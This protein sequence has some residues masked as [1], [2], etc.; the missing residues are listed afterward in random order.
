M[1]LWQLATDMTRVALSY[2]HLNTLHY[3]KDACFS[4]GVTWDY[5]AR[6][7]ADATR[8]VKA[9]LAAVFKRSD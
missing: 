2:T 8:S 1:S 3:V 4:R 6:A 7:H 9:L 5:D